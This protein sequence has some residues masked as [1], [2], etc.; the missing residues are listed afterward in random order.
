MHSGSSK[1]HLRCIVVSDLSCQPAIRSGEH[2]HRLQR[3]TCRGAL[4]V[5]SLRVTGASPAAR[6]LTIRV[7]DKVARKVEEEEEEVEEDDE[8]GG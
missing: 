5:T 7:R 2:K 4:F 8:M 1:R 3:R 6:L